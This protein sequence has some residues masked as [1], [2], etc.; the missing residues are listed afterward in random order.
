MTD[1]EGFQ[2]RAKVKSFLSLV[3]DI[4][5]LISK[6]LR[7]EIQLFRRELVAGLKDVGWGFALLAVSLTFVTL[8][9]ALIILSAV[10]AISLVLP[11]WGAALSAGGLALIAAAI[12]GAIGLSR[13]AKR[14]GKIAT[15]TVESLREDIRVL[16]GDN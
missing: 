2:S 4:P 11:L 8:G 16:R 6:L 1:S 5:H 15:K 14:S 7:A 10:F 9:A 3:T 13:M 12:F